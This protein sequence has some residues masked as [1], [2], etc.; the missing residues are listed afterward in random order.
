[1]E[2]GACSWQSSSL[3]APPHGLRRHP[4]VFIGG[5]VPH[6]SEGDHRLFDAEA[7][8]GGPSIWY[9]ISDTSSI[10]GTWSFQIPDESTH[11]LDLLDF[12][13]NQVLLLLA[14]TF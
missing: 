9:Q 8:F 7:L 6:L 14:K 13:R 10:K 4:E 11:K 12:E 5:E 1:M 3:A 2:Q